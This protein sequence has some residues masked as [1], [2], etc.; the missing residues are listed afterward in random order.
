MISSLWNDAGIRETFDRRSQFQ[1]TDSIAYFYEHLDR[2]ASPTYT[3]TQQ[4]ILYCRKTTK[5]IIE[6]PII[7]EGIPFLFVDV[8][9]QRTQRQKW[10]Q[11]FDSVTAILFIASTSEFD[12]VFLLYLY[13]MNENDKLFLFLGFTRRQSYKSVARSEK[14]FRCNCQ[15]QNFQVY[16]VH[17]FPEQNGFVGGK[18]EK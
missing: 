1:L 7:V 2:I 5:G 15:Q 3:P 9:G 13:E 16:F 14:Y 10:L 12:Q 8:G 4:D 11:C 6:F 17:S 18:S